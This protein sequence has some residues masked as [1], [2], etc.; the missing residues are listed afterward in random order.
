MWDMCKQMIVWQHISHCFAA[1]SFHLDSV[2]WR[3]FCVAQL[4]LSP[5]QWLYCMYSL[6][7]YIITS[8]LMFK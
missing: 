6:C 4:E 7:G 1:C 2:S 5:F 8:L 3:A